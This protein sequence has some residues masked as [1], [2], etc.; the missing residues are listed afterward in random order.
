[1]SLGGSGNED[2][3][4]FHSLF[5]EVLVCSSPSSEQLFPFEGALVAICPEKLQLLLTNHEGVACFIA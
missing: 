1:M 5:A 3:L 2:L 4:H